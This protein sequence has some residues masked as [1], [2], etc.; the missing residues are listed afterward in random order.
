M[1][2]LL[3]CML[4]GEKCEILFN[5]PKTQRFDSIRLIDTRSWSWCYTILIYID[6]LKCKTCFSTFFSYNIYF[7][8]RYFFIPFFTLVFSF[9]LFYYYTR[10]RND[11]LLQPDKKAGCVETDYTQSEPRGSILK[12]RYS[13]RLIVCLHVPFFVFLSRSVVLGVDDSI[14]FT[15]LLHFFN[16]PLD[17]IL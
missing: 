4:I 12:K 2:Y 9:V 7:W 8:W 17:F 6:L 16:S 14:I 11:G 15:C 1:S 5:S 13:S 10:G 3:T